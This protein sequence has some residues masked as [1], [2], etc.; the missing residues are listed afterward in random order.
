VPERATITNMGAEL[1][2]T[3]SL[4][5]SDE[6]TRAFLKAQGRA[7]AWRELQPDADARYDATIEI[8]LHTL[9]ARLNQAGNQSFDFIGEHGFS[10]TAGELRY[11]AVA[12]GLVVEGDVD[13]DGRADF[14][15]E[16]QGLGK[17]SAGDFLL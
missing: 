11:K 13:G 4:F 1:G 2:A 12:G 5:P 16:L 7:K 8:D 10:H 6:V 9:D 17:L 15:I 14:Q 3:T